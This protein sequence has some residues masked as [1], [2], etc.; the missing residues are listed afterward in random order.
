MDR[1]KL[2]FP[3]PMRDEFVA[4]IRK[5]VLDHKDL[6]ADLQCETADSLTSGA[7]AQHEAEANEFFGS[8][9]DDDARAEMKRELGSWWLA[10]AEAEVE[11]VV[12]KAVEYGAL[13][14][15]DIGHDLARTA[16][17]VVSDEEAA[18]MGVYFYVRGKLARWTDALV[19]HARPSDDT[20]HDLGVYVRMAQRIR[21]AGGWPGL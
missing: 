14:L 6:N 2:D 19:R 15:I 4:M 21:A 5:F 20:L 17:R 7:V 8:L 18:E 13:D 11:A 10:L 16:G 9:P 3:A 1:I 12:P